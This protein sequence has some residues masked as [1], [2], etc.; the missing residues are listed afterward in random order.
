MWTK[1]TVNLAAFHYDGFYL[2]AP[3]DDFVY[4]FFLVC[5][6]CIKV[7]FYKARTDIVA[8]SQLN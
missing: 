4:S 3:L 5:W 7:R 2:N 6:L 8:Q 1:S